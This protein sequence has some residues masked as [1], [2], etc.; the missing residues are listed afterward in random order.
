MLLVLMCLDGDPASSPSPLLL[1]S[2]RQILHILNLHQKRRAEQ[3]QAREV[4]KHTDN[5]SLVCL[6]NL[7]N[8]VFL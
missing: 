8:H 3:I 4:S 2:L 1:R 7:K 5:I 6:L